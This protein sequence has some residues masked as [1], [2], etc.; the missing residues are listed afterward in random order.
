MNSLRRPIGVGAAL[1][2]CFSTLGPAAADTPKGGVPISFAVGDANGFV[3]I[4]ETITPQGA[5]IDTFQSGDTIIKVLGSAGSSVS[6][7][8]TG[9]TK[10]QRGGLGIAMNTVRSKT[11]EDAM[12]YHNSGRSV[13]G[14]LVALGVPR[15][16]AE[17]LFGGMETADGTNP[18]LAQKGLAQ[19]APQ[20]LLTSASAPSIPQSPLV[21]SPTT[22]WDTQCITASAEGGKLYG[23]GC[24]T[25]YIAHQNG[26]DWWLATKYLF[27]AHSTDTSLFPKRLK[28]VGWKVQWASGNQVTS[29]RPSSTTIIQS[30]CKTISYGLTIWGTGYNQST[31]ICPDT[32]GIWE[33][34]SLKSGARW[35]GI[36][37]GTAWEAAEGLQEVHSPPGV[38][39]SHGSYA[40]W[41][42]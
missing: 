10:D 40:M 2:L 17:R 33:L 31:T 26:T 39:E 3:A 6:F 36:E 18:Y 12:A 20:A 22:V 38:S 32:H 35:Q 9:P 42:Y 8:P 21:A 41:V 11:A 37:Q 15:A 7:Y 28:Q 25:F 5:V 19:S 16:D 13:V 14:D 34:S 27:S 30:T 24:S 4:S 1:V 29:W 23:Y